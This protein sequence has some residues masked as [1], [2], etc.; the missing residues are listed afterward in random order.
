[1]TLRIVSLPIDTATDWATLTWP[2]RNALDVLRYGVDA[3]AWLADLGEVIASVVVSGPGALTLAPV[4]LV[5]V[6]NVITGWVVRIGGGAPG[7]M[8]VVRS[9]VTL[10]RGEVLIVDVAL[11]TRT[12][13]G[14]IYVPVSALTASSLGVT[15]L[16][17]QVITYN[18]VV[19]T[20]G[21]A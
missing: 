13:A 2:D 4:E 18:G 10:A 1:M 6:A 7:E 9:I 19:I 20:I 16:A 12:D 21:E 11:H 5:T 15:T 3:T 17:G 8:D 14:L